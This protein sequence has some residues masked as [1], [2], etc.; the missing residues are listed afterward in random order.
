MNSLPCTSIRLK[1][2]LTLAA[3]VGAA[4]GVAPSAD[5]QINP[6]DIGMTFTAA[7]STLNI[8]A[9]TPTGYTLARTGNTLSFDF[10]VSDTEKPQVTASGAIQVGK[11][12]AY[13]DRLTFGATI[14]GSLDWGI[15]SIQFEEEGNGPWNEQSGI[16]YFAFRLDNGGS[17]FSYGWVEAEYNDAANQMTLNRYGLEAT[18]DIGTTAG[19]AVPEPAS[20]VLLLAFGA[21]GIA[22]FR[23]RRSKTVTTTA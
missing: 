21:G 16:N 5:A 9:I 17:S 13:V 10:R 23:R 22:A 18:A 14:D 20:S 19:A 4:L 6:V 15:N 2:I 8:G 12:G 1:K 11:S 7:G 3:P